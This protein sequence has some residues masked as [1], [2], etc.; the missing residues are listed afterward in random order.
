MH[1]GEKKK[2]LK[3]KMSILLSDSRYFWLVALKFV[4]LSWHLEITEK[5]MRSGR[6]LSSS[7]HAPVELQQMRLKMV[8][9]NLQWDCLIAGAH[10]ME[11]QSPL[12]SWVNRFPSRFRNRTISFCHVLESHE[13][14]RCLL[15]DIRQF[16]CHFSIFNGSFICQRA[17]NLIRE[18]L[19]S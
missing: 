7:E 8:I 17:T 10:Q 9:D 14:A 15:F 1:F 4:P 16:Y 6:L 18:G 2:K 3:Y 11:P 19:Y 12:I 13:Y 5:A